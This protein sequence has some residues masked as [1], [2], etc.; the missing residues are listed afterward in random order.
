MIHLFWKKR[1][2]LEEKID[3]LEKQIL[4]LSENIKT[5]KKQGPEY[6]F[7]ID[8]VDIHQPRLDQLTFQLENLDIE[9]LSGALNVGNNFGVTVG[10]EKLPLK[11][12]KH[13]QKKESGDKSSDPVSIHFRA[14]EE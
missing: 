6:H 4:Q 12:A 8:R 13:P 11:T 14:K 2:K 9:E 5:M 1:I 10:K 3:I 7:H